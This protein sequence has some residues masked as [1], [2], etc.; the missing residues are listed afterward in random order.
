M[1]HAHLTE[2]LVQGQGVFA[3]T[4]DQLRAAGLTAE[5]AMAQVNRLIDQQAYTR[6]ADDIFPGLGRPVPA[7]D[8][9]D[10]AHTPSG[11]RGGRRGG[12]CGWG[13]L[14][15]FARLAERT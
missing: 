12:G 11:A 15:W 2:P 14:R 8:R 1:H 9:P 4:L 7:A 13:A 6:A 5:Q 10:L 3:A